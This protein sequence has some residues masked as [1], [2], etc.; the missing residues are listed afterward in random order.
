MHKTKV[1]P[2]NGGGYVT[3]CNCGWKHPGETPDR[4]VAE[5]WIRVHEKAIERIRTHLA[6]KTPRL[7]DE[8]DYYRSKADDPDETPENRAIWKQLADELSVRL[9]DDGPPDANQLRLL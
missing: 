4:Q 7:Q 3:R 1:V 5:D 2:L 9:N 8:R 6:T